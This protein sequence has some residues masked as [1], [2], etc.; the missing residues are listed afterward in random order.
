MYNGIKK[1][2]KQEVNQDELQHMGRINWSRVSK[3]Q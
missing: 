3:L 2:T 1:Y